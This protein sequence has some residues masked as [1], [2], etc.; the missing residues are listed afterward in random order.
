M[1]QSSVGTMKNLK[2]DQLKERTRVDLLRMTNDYLSAYE[3]F[4]S[5]F[6]TIQ[7]FTKFGPLD[8]PIFVQLGQD[9]NAHYGNLRRLKEELVAFLGYSQFEQNV[10]FEISGEVIAK[11]GLFILELPEKIQ[12][13]A[14]YTSDPFLKGS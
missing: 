2:L 9:F 11:A 5:I 7:N 12:S 3:K 13:S 14:I 4:E 6:E 8:K 10:L 1:A